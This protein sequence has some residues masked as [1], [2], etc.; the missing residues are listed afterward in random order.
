MGSLGLVRGDQRGY[1]V[2]FIFKE[3]KASY[4]AKCFI[5]VENPKCVEKRNCSTLAMLP[6]FFSQCYKCLVG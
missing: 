6:G 5:C 2:S 4:R 1:I 3:N